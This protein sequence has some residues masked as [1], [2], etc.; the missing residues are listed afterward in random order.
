MM[1]IKSDDPVSL[2]SNDSV[3]I[4]ST[5]TTTH[6]HDIYF[7]EFGETKDLVDIYNLLK[8]AGTDDKVV[9]HLSSN[10]GGYV[11]TG[12]QLLNTIN[13]NTKCTVE[14]QVPSKTYSMGSV[15]AVGM[16]LSGHPV[17]FYPHTYLMFHDY[18]GGLTGKGSE[19]QVAMEAD[20]DSWHD[21]F[22]SY[23]YPFLLKNEIRSV[24]SGQDLII[25]YDDIISPMSR[26]V[27]GIV[28]RLNRMKKKIKVIK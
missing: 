14:V 19:M 24:I 22:D 16:L 25:G 26:K 27:D 5:P 9:F 6:V 4:R 1:P 18:S 17:S 13:Y 12:I 8:T 11:D 10:P 2:D 15:F 23:T 3:K 7:F 20:R 28:T 21:F